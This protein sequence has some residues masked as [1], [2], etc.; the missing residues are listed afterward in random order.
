[1]GFRA[2]RNHEGLAY[3]YLDNRTP[4]V[5]DMAG[6]PTPF[7]LLGCFGTIGLFALL[8]MDMIFNLLVVFLPSESLLRTTIMDNLLEETRK[9]SWG[10][11]VFDSL[12]LFL[13]T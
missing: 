1:M 5:G 10:Y 12:V 4:K 3:R 2:P 8:Y 9:V 7:F 11:F 13:F 6:L